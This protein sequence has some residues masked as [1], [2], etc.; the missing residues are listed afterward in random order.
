MIGLRK[1]CLNVV[2]KPVMISEIMTLQPPPLAPVNLSI[3]TSWPHSGDN[4][5][6]EPRFLPPEQFLL[7]TLVF[8]LAVTALLATM[9]VRF[10]RFRHILIFER[11][12]FP[13][14]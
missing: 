14:G 7:T 2:A 10:R 5:A 11:R 12:A 3:I 9:L 6:V 4:S 1:M 13:D 8:K